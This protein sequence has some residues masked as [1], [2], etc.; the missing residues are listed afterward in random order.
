MNQLAEIVQLKDRV[1]ESMRDVS[2]EVSRADVEIR[3]LVRAKPLGM[4]VAAAA[5]GFLVGRFLS[6]R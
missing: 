6:R 3:R 2:R 1:E 5:I 4:A